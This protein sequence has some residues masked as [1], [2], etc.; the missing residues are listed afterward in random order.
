[1]KKKI[2]IPDGFRGKL[3][4]D[5]EL[6]ELVPF[7]KEKKKSELTVMTYDEM[8]PTKSMATF[9]SPVFTSKRKKRAYEKAHGFY[10]TGGDH[11][12]EEMEEI[13]RVRAGEAPRGEKP[14]TAAELDREAREDKELV[15]AAAMDVKYGRVPFT[16]KQ[17]QMFKEEERKWGQSYK[18]KV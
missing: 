6:E 15:E 18:I 14:K 12:K 3:I 7:I 9:D 13:Q 10:E 1:M 8:P 5:E 2:K 11:I 17:K 16:E 4:W